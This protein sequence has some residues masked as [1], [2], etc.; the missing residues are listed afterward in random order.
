MPS[1][2]ALFRCLRVVCRKG[3]VMERAMTLQSSLLKINNR[4]RLTSNTNGMKVST[5]LVISAVISLTMT[6]II[7]L[8]LKDG[9]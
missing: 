5:A 8:E 9:N 2:V 7:S 6:I 1:F 4:Y 3:S